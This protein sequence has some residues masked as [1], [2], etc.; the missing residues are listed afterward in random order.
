M[1]LFILIGQQS[2]DRIVN[3]YSSIGEI[4]KLSQHNTLKQTTIL[5]YCFNYQGYHK[6]KKTD[7]MKPN[8]SFSPFI[9]EDVC[10]KCLGNF[11]MIPK[12]NPGI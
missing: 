6:K 10:W 1:S 9:I 4:F 3:C 5:H 7:K 2:L 8:I 11:D 12:F